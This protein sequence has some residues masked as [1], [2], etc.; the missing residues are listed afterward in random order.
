M[1]ETALSSHKSCF[2]CREK[3]RSL[4]LVNKKD[5]VHA[6]KYHNIYIKHHA[7]CCDAHYDENGLIR[8]EEFYI[9]PTKKK[10]YS[11]DTIKMFKH[12][13]AFSISYYSILAILANFKKSIV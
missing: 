13:K 12:L 9:I 11:Q 5:I 7:R 1:V 3:T 2:I 8:N 6:Y 10:Y 4:H